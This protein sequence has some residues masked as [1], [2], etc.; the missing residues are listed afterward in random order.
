MN[1]PAL[2]TE[3]LILRG[4]QESDVTMV[5]ELYGDETNS[6]YIGGTKTPAECWRIVAAFIG[7]WTLRGYGLWCVTR[8][9]TGEVIG[10]TGL[11]FPAGWPEPELGYALHPTHHGQ[12]FASETTRAALTSAY[13]DFGWTTAISLIDKDNAA[14][15]NVARKLGATLEQKDAAVLQ[16][17]GDI[18]RHQPPKQFLGAAT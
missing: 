7:H 11:W 1:I 18:W 10:W 13:T 5:T 17:T 14:S 15:Q 6:R 8:K 9:D 4:W 2:N 16:F 12:G 3:R